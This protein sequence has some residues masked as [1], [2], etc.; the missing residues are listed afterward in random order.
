M[1]FFYRRQAE[2]IATFNKTGLAG[3]LFRAAW[4]PAYVGDS[5]R[6]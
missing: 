4:R 6:Y 3:A 2:L 1:G 5:Q